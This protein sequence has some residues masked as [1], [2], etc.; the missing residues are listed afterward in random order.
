VR[1][2]G[3]WAQPIPGKEQT[4]HGVYRL[5]ADGTLLMVADDFALPNGLAF[6]PDESMLYIDDSA[7]KHIR[8]FDVK[9]DGTLSGGRVLLDMASGDPGVPDGLKV[10]VAGNVFC[11]G[12][13]GV[14]VFTPAGEHLGTIRIPERQTANV[15]WGQS[16]QD[17]R[18]S[19]S[20]LYMTSHVS[21]YRLKL[22]VPGI[23]VPV[24]R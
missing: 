22:A 6:S 19:W 2:A 16:G 23:P 15:A 9:P 24:G 13:G 5:T 1:P 12:P 18:E 4:A 17:P 14:W 21:V 11:T 8:A 3:W 20:W 7:H 10:D